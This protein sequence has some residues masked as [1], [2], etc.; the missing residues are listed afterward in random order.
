MTEPQKQN[1]APAAAGLNIYVRQAAHINGII[2]Q[3]LNE[4][5]WFAALFLILC[6]PAVVRLAVRVARESKAED[7]RSPF[8]YVM[9]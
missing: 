2:R 6:Y 4:R 3:C 8:V 7:K 1:T 9:R 5:A